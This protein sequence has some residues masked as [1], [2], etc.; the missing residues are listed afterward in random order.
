[1]APLGKGGECVVDVADAEKHGRSHRIG[2]KYPEE[3]HTELDQS[4]DEGDDP[5]L[6]END[7]W[8][9]EYAFAAVVQWYRAYVQGFSSSNSVR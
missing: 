1:M 5:S 6:P 8:T 4:A 7:Q 9:F 2:S 3:A